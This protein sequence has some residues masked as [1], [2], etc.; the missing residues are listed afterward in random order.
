MLYRLLV[1]FI[2]FTF[3]LYAEPTV[4]QVKAAVSANPTLLESPQAKA[5]MADKGVSQSDVKNALKAETTDAPAIE[6]K[7][8]VAENEIENSEESESSEES[9]DGDDELKK[10][11]KS[12]KRLNPFKYKTSEALRA[13]L[14]AKQKQLTHKKLSRYSQL[15]YSN[16]N[17]IDSSS[18]PTPDN[19]FISAGDTLSIHVYG[20]RDKVY[21]LKVGNEGTVDLAFIGP[22]KIGGMQFKQAKKYLESKLKTHFKMSDFSIN[23]NG[24]STIQVSLIGEVNHPGIYNLSSFSTVR[25]LLI[26]AKGVRNNASVRE[27]I[28]KRN[29][30]VIAKIDFYDLLFKGNKIADT[31]LKHGDIVVIKKARKL[32]SIDGYVNNAAIFELN[33]QEK[34][35]DLIDYAGG[36]KVDASKSNIKITRYVDNS[37]LETFN[38]AY[39]N[40][41][42]FK[43]QDGD[44]V[45]IYSL[46]FTAKSSVNIYGNIIRPGSYRLQKD[47]T[48]QSLLK[49]S[50]KDG[51][52][53]FFLPQTNFEYGIVKSYSDDLTYVTKTFNLSNVLKGVENIDLNMHDEIFIFSNN[54]LYSSSYITTKGSLLLDAGKLMHFKGITLQDAINASGVNGVLEDKVRVTTYNTHDYMPKTEFYSLKAQANTVLSPYDEV[55]VYD[56]YSK[57]ILEPVSIKGE[58]VRPSTVFYEKGMSVAKLLKIAG[59]FNKKAYTKSIRILRYT[60]DEN[61]VRQ[62][63]VLNYNLGETALEEIKL[64]PYDEVSV[65]KILA[66]DAQDYEVVSISGEVQNPT[67]VKFGE[68]MRV[69]NL[70]IMAGGLSKKAYKKSLSIVRHYI[71]ETQTRKQKILEYNLEETSVEDITLHPYDEVKILKIPKWEERRTVTLA[72]EFRFPGVYTIQAGEKLSSVIERAGGYTEEAFVN[73]AVF[74]RES[75]RKNQ[76]DNYNNSLAKIKRELAIYNAMP[77]NAKQQTVGGGN[78]SGT[79]NEVIREAQKY[80]PLGRIS[81]KLDEDLIAFKES[82]FNLILKDKDTLTIPG[83]IDTITVFGEVFNP[84]SFVY[85]EDRDAESYIELASG[86]LRSADAQSIYVIHADGTSEPLGGGWL[87]SGSDIQKGDTIVVPMYIKEYN[88][89]DLWDTAAK[90]LSSFAITAAALNTLGIVN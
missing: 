69:S 64:E 2:I 35:K 47:K 9:T 34:L 80:Q 66:W 82:N 88:Q 58:V 55:E 25:D 29:A 36:M 31:L 1:T 44:K 67:K 46:D 68:G 51:Y 20:D 84:T 65:F 8:E 45:Y 57:N 48:L 59:G 40:A 10:A 22:V 79:L 16:K 32:V 27:I 37:R 89:L 86:M 38:I 61:Q 11:T 71:D 56:Y 49:N 15:F 60:V 14:S 41:K 53:K 70:I 39:E 75:I 78:T 13:E 5:M 83:H 90:V 21:A 4:A 6:K 30:K 19:Y 33:K 81:V 24:Y 77:A 23:V 73:G 28:V 18:L 50:L 3:S 62:Q 26:N 63:T 52:K 42:K 54:D 72:G 87:S 76:L 74:T 43:M 7:S 85:D 12:N 17:T